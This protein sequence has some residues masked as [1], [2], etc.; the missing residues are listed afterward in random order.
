MSRIFSLRLKSCFSSHPRT[1][2]FAISKELY[3]FWSQSGKQFTLMISSWDL[4]HEDSNL[5]LGIQ[6]SF[7]FSHSTFIAQNCVCYYAR[8][9]TIYPILMTPTLFYTRFINTHKHS[10]Q[11]DWLVYSL[12]YTL[13]L[14]IV[15]CFP[16]SISGK[17][18][19]KLKHSEFL[20]SR[21]PQVSKG[22]DFLC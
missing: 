20:S 8:L 16:H 6:D 15:C 1:C 22:R 12:K 10:T 3:H 19:T 18:D 11:L 7:S 21:K 2:N 4:Q 13:L 14:P 9:S 5:L 17:D